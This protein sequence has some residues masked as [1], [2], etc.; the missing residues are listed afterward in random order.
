M[1]VKNDNF[2]DFT[3]FFKVLKESTTLN[4]EELFTALSEYLYEDASVKRKSMKNETSDILR[5]KKAFPDKVRRFAS[6]DQVDAISKV[7]KEYL[8]GQINNPNQLTPKLLY[9]IQQEDC[10]F[11]KADY[12][13]LKNQQDTSYIIA[14]IYIKT[15]NTSDRSKELRHSKDYNPFKNYHEPISI[16]QKDTIKVESD[17]RETSAYL[18][19]KYNTFSITKRLLSKGRTQGIERDYDLFDESFSIVSDSEGNTKPLQDYMATDENLIIIG[20]GGIGKTTALFTYINKCRENKQYENIPL[21]IRLSNC[22]TYT[23]HEHMILNAL[24]SSIGYAVN[25]RA[26]DSYKDIID[27]FSI[28]PHDGLPKY[29][30]LLDGFNEIT[31]MDMGEV[32]FSI[33]KE[34]NSLCDYRNVRIILTTRESDLYGIKMSDF[35]PVKATGIDISDVK[36]FLK[37]KLSSDDFIAVQAD[38]KLLQY[39]R[40][41]L[42]LKMFTYSEDICG[43]IPKTRGEILFHYYNGINGI[44]TE[45]QNRSEKNDRKTS[46]TAGLL[47]DFL[48]PQIGY[49]M[50]ANELFQIDIDSFEALSNDAGDFIERLIKYNPVL[51]KQYNT[52]VLGIRKVISA[53]KDINVDDALRFLTDELGVLYKDAEERIYFCHQ[54]VRDYF[55]ALYCVNGITDMALSDERV[56]LNV[57][58]MVYW[59]FSRWSEERIQ[60]IC[61]I[62]KVYPGIEIG[63]LIRQSLDKMRS[64]SFGGMDYN[65]SVS[66]LISTLSY[67]EQGDLSNYDLSQLD[68][69]ECRLNDKNFSNPY[70]NK[71]TSFAGAIISETTFASEAHENSV[72][73]WTVSDEEHYIVSLD[74]NMELKIWNIANQE[75]IYTSRVLDGPYY[76]YVERIKFIESLNILIVM[77]IDIYSE[78][79]MAWTYNTRTHEYCSYYTANPEN[80]RILY[81]DY[82]YFLEKLFIIS[83]NSVGYMYRIGEEV[84][85]DVFPINPILTKY[86]IKSPLIKKILEAFS[87]TNLWEI[88]LLDDNMALLVEGDILPP[89]RSSKSRELNL[90]IEN[91]SNRVL[92]SDVEGLEEPTERHIKLYLYDRSSMDIHPL[93]FESFFG[94]NMSPLLLADRDDD[95][96]HEKIAISKDKRKI[97]LFNTSRL[98]IYDISDCDYVFKPIGIVPS[99]YNWVIKYCNSSDVLTIYNYSQV[100]HYSVEKRE[101][102]RHT[103]M[104]NDFFYHR[105]VCTQNYKLNNVLDNFCSFVITNLYS[106]KNNNMCLSDKIEVSLSFISQNGEL[107][108][109]Y[110]NGTLICLDK[111]KLTYISS[112]NICSGKHILSSIYSE[113]KNIICAV[114]SPYHSNLLSEEKNILFFDVENAERVFMNG[115]INSGAVLKYVFDDKYVVVITN[116]EVI[117]VSTETFSVVDR[118]EWNSELSAYLFVDVIVEK[119]NFNLVYSI[120]GDSEVRGIILVMT[121]ENDRIHEC[122]NIKIPC[123]NL[124]EIDSSIVIRQ[125]HG[126]KICKIKVPNK[127]E[128]SILYVNGKNEVFNKSLEEWNWVYLENLSG[129]LARHALR[130]RGNGKEDNYDLKR[131]YIKEKYIVKKDDKTFIYDVRNNAFE[132]ILIGKSEPILLDKDEKNIY[133]LD[134]ESNKIYRYDVKKRCSPEASNYLH[135]NILVDGCDFTEL[136]GYRGAIPRYMIKSKM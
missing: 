40:I 20:E 110:S 52:H 34:I 95:V 23:D 129:F 116:Y 119:N 136:R 13:F 29:T 47:L 59:G 104:E 51:N 14:Y 38:N 99:G 128:K 46:L 39:L 71:K 113:E 115:I 87:K 57:N 78:F 117:A 33:A 12:E 97:A 125:F 100:M 93:Q 67:F 64:V 69:R 96:I 89:N 135:T 4:N 88:Y 75:C 63:T 111:D 101:I 16:K 121:I 55:A 105:I 108:V 9:L 45:K 25:G 86:L 53:Y 48:L 90:E 22:S 109:L 30:L 28:E 112:Y 81:F 114:T 133:L 36:C 120:K 6:L 43:Y 131:E 44:Y 107:C 61:E 50:A 42:F 37:D 18:E 72:R 68:L 66:N 17:L 92:M 123:I 84:P 32:R 19:N 70:T 132:E 79:T 130:I 102:L 106:L 127:T 74:S 118:K 35:V 24:M 65:F 122:D 83:D 126:S 5:K 94:N 2:L 56:D 31:S 27:E 49:Y 26:T 11:E 15:V 80:E 58:N 60:L 73:A 82:D 54:Y 103:S 62:I 85:K 1:E 134:S 8:M 7:Y 98:F 124:D 21:Y 76:Y 3:T 41:P 10:F 77:D 91:E